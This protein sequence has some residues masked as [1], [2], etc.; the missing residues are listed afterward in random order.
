MVRFLVHRPI[1]VIM[2]FIALLMLGVVSYRMLPVSLMPDVDIPEI[3]VQVSYPKSS[4]RELEN[5]VVSRMRSDLM[6]V[7]NLRDI[8]TETRD[9]MATLRL[10]FD[11][12]A[13]IDYAFIEVNEKIDLGMGSYPSDMDRPRVIKAS[14]NDIPVFY[15]N[16]TSKETPGL[17]DKDRYRVEANKLVELSEFCDN[18]VRRRMEQLPEVAM[19]DMSGLASP[20]ILIRPKRD[21]MESLGLNDNIFS[22][23]IAGR[24]GE[25]G[26]LSVRDGY[27]QYTIRFA[28]SLI[29]AGDI[30]DIYLKANDKMYQ[31]SDLAEIEMRPQ[32]ERGMFLDGR[33]RGVTM[34]VI[35]QSEAK[36]ADLKASLGS[37]IDRF[38][39]E[40]PGMNFSVSQDQSSLLDYSI[41]NLLQNLIMGCILS[42]VVLFFFLSDFRAPV[43]IGITVPISLVLS[44]IFFKLIGLSINIISLSGLALGIGMIVDCSIIV[45]DNILRYKAQGLSLVEA[46]IRGTNEVI[47]PMLSSTL[48]TSSVFLPLVFLSGMAGALFFDEAVSVTLGNFAS[49]V[50]AIV[51][52]PVLVGVLYAIGSR[53]R[54]RKAER[55]ESSAWNRLI[56]RITFGEQFERGYERGVEWVF[57][58]KLITVGIVGLLLCSVV[59]LFRVIEVRTL[60][61]LDQTE[62]RLFVE[63]NENI[64]LEENQRRVNALLGPLDSLLVQSNSYI[65][66]QDFV[67]NRNRDI[68]YYEAEI[69]LKVRKPELLAVTEDSVR[70]FFARNYPMATL[71]VLP[72]SNLFEQ[73]FDQNL[74]PLLAKVGIPTGN[75]PSADSIA[76]FV[77]EADRVMK[78]SVPNV[79]AYKE[80]LRISL[81][82]ERLVLYGISE[83][84][85]VSAIRSAFG[86]NNVTVLRSS[87]R[88]LPIKLG[89]DARSVPQILSTLTVK[90]SRGE[91]FPVSLFVSTYRD[92]DMKYIIGG[93]QGEY[94]PLS[95]YIDKSQ[96]EQAKAVLRDLVRQKGYAQVQFGGSIV[97][98]KALFA[99][100][101]LILLI[102][103]LLLYFI[104]AAQF[105]SLMQPLIVLLE[106]PIDIAGAL[107]VLWVCGNSLNLMSG[108]GIV[109][110]CGVIIND[111]ILKVDTINQFRKEGL[112]LI[113]AIKT[114]GRIRLRSIVMTSLTTIFAVLPFLW[115][116]DMGSELQRPLSLALIGGMTLGTLVSL[117]VIPLAYWFVYRKDTKPSQA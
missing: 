13:S 101:G 78:S 87:Q 42:F 25:G 6:Q 30:S 92:R 43:L 107:F 8:Q 26:S 44:F 82:Q 59:W 35:Q 64:H 69:Y 86:D 90:N 83:G 85:V 76:A 29:T 70:S 66:E 41:G 84:S 99:E 14:A 60:P 16:I 88:F 47:V 58:N 33:T 1:A 62:M 100:L 49:F 104:L 89:S 37:L 12:G 105:E 57:R 22:T 63:W 38:R 9:G 45:I 111:S 24:T 7:G 115:S 72:P 94:I 109:V 117:F 2:I 36:M 114:G 97:E 91:N 53:R 108:I 110:M 15:L 65:G 116:N 77:A 28:S 74:P 17:P 71:S 50:V 51:L 98:N 39:L 103:F 81:N 21:K 112:P 93:Q 61:D 106:I 52:L 56:H 10:L 18:V 79:M 55:G 40:Y 96:M 4:A 27:F 20:E 23:A 46:C 19:V 113:Q 68:D 75:H 5:A 31:L 67:L 102:S 3:T 95:F 48:T 32:T 73:I 11:Y 80:F 34:A 54:A